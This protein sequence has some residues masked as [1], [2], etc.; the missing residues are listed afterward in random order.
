[1]IQYWLK[2]LLWESNESVLK[3][4]N[5]WVRV[6]V[7]LIESCRLR[8]FAR[9]LAVDQYYFEGFVAQEWMIFHSAPMTY[10]NWL[11]TFNQ[12]FHFVLITITI[13]PA[14][15]SYLQS[16]S[17]YFYSCLVPSYFNNN[18]CISNFWTI[19]FFTTQLPG[20][21]QDLLKLAQMEQRS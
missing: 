7:S 15:D 6:V 1:M 21:N 18:V 14:L 12:L 17:S 11:A 3:V 16:L 9:L 5:T 8:S 2:N 10:N 19:S 13:D 4:Y 20:K